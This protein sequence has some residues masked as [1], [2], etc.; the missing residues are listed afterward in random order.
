VTEF[1]A[2][3]PEQVEQASIQE[4]TAG[5]L[6]IR[7]Q[8]RLAVMRA[9][10]AF[11][12]D[13]TVDEHHAIRSVGFSPVG[14]VMGSCVYHL[15]YSTGRLNCGYNGWFFGGAMAGTAPVLAAEAVREALYEARMLAIDRMR[16]ECVGVGGDGV[17]A[18]LL[19]IAPFPAGGLEFKAIGTAVRA[20]GP[21]RPR[22]PFM[23]DLSGQDFAKLMAAGWVPCGF[24]LGVGVMIRHDDYQTE[25][26]QRSWNNTEVTGRTNLVSAA[27]QAA[28]EHLRADCARHGGQGVVV[29]SSTLKVW[30]QACRTGGEHQHDHVA[31]AIL[32][33][34]AI[35]RFRAGALPP[36][37]L[38]IMRLR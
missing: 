10:H 7:A 11:T 22:E 31:E 16:Q 34:T 35:T 6:P 19:T 20:D 9:D 27:R 21:V 32:I 36:R 17:V 28:R 2:W 13:L 12:S 26:Q 1:D 15:G 37:P 18:V 3:T 25:L 38:Q 23:S 24:L 5:R 33:G 8:Q 4:L 30:G 14:Q 29:Q